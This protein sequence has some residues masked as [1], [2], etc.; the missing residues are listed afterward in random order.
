[1]S[2]FLGSIYST[3]ELDTGKLAG[4]VTGAKRTITGLTGDL[5]SMGKGGEQSFGTLV[6]ASALGNIAALGFSKG[7]SIL[8][9]SFTTATK[10]VDTLNNS[11]RSFLNMG[12]DKETISST[13]EK[14]NKSILGL[15]TS[16]D[17]AVRM[18]TLFASATGDLPKSQ[19]LFAALNNGILGFGGTADQVNTA[20]IQLSQAFAGGRVYAQD[21][22][23]MLNAGLGPAL[24]AIAKQMGIT[25]SQLKEGLG[26]GTIAV[27]DFQDQLIKLN[28]QGGGGL[29][30][31]QQIAQDSTKGINT[32][33]ANA[34][35]A[36][37]RGMAAIITAVGPERISGAIAG[38]GKGFETGLKQVAHIVEISMPAITAGFET[39]GKI[40]AGTA[41]FVE[42][43][44]NAFKSGNPVIQGATVFLGALAVTMG[45]I[46]VLSAIY[47]ASF[48]IM[49]AVTTGFGVALAFVTSPLFLIAAAVAAVIAI[50]FLLYKNWDTISAF[51]GKVWNGIKDVV[52]NAWQSV[53]GF[54]S[55][56]WEAIVGFFTKYGAVILAVVLPFIGIPL[57]IY[58]NWSTITAFFSNLWST[59]VSGFQT[60]VQMAISFFQQLPYNI[61]LAV[62]TMVRILWDFATQTVPNFISTV[63]TWIAGL[64]GQVAT[65]FTNMATSAVAIAT[66]MFNTVVA[67]FT[68]LPGQVAA[69]L[70]AAWSTLVN[71]F[72]SMYN[73]ATSIVSNTIS[74]VVSF[75]SGLP[76]RAS[77][78]I[79]GLASS[80]G[81]KFNEMW[82]TAMN[83]L[84]SFGTEVVNFMTSLPGKMLAAIGNF[85]GAAYNKFK[86]IAGS[87][88]DGFKDGLGIHSPSYIER[89]M[90][91]IDDQADATVRNLNDQMSQINS[92][93]ASAQRVDFATGA[94][95]GS[96]FG[97]VQGGAAAGGDQTFNITLPNVQNGYDF[98]REFKLATAGR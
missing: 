1:M 79:S 47:I 69:F 64:P 21:W 74:A 31:L 61:G 90:F 81:G 41:H 94:P 40:I 27:S 56:T 2:L 4:Q 45:I 87:M 37:A 38:F 20:V 6:K 3:M 96:D 85:A 42:S 55:R 59:I 51:A 70:S 89:A 11:T 75:F 95:G 72:T 63:V 15:P 48:G 25:T 76:G 22:Y 19:R 39:V 78:A 62:G 57:L 44:V 92:L 71:W 97:A 67:F 9:D 88:W 84:K 7:V 18:V 32:G 29:V 5:E 83:A 68:A 80:I 10:R 91:A 65:F 28:E 58:Q 52:V 36:I 24:N 13:M 35:T 98:A 53:T 26:D 14:I 73:S 82:S 34:Q 54:F 49:T 12:F 33:M 66:G 86:S 46:E 60:G 93:A 30:S 77:S 50:G 17:S 8:Q 43:W 23:S 16:L